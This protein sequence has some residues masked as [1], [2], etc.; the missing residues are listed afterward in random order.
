V[1][2]ALFGGSFDPPHVAH[3]MA[4]LW[5]IATGR[6]DRVLWAPCHH[7][8][9]GKELAPFEDRLAMCRLAAEALVGVEVSPIDRDAGAEG[10]TLLV[11]RRLKAERPADDLVVLVGADLVAERV[12]WHGYEEIERLAGFL[13]VGRSGFASPDG[14]PDLPALSSS[15]VRAALARGD[16]VSGWVPRAVLAYVRAHGLYGAR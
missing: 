9:F 13:I 15:A 8:P 11:L 1:R 14:V 3:Q 6:V 16:D 4:S 7:H 10:R 2:I 12:R 5:A